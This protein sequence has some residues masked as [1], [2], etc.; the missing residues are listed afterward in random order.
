[1]VSVVLSLT[2]LRRTS[3]YVRLYRHPCRRSRQY[4]T[5]SRRVRS[6]VQSCSY[7]TL[8]TCCSLSGATSCMHMRMLMTHRYGFCHPYEVDV[9]KL[10][11]SACRPIDDVS[12][13]MTSN[14]LQIDPA[15]TEILWCAS[16]RRQ[17]QIPV[18][19]VR[20]GDTFVSPVTLHT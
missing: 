8:Q 15:Q 13:W 3:Q 7:Y 6:S 1:M 19:Q 16:A 4:S 5:E 17:K 2:G 18:G 12:L 20:I 9:L 14:R 10:R 11:L